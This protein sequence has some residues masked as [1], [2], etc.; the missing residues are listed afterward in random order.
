MSAEA[1]LEFEM[2]FGSGIE[3]GLA[4]LVA[5]Y[6]PEPGLYDEMLTAAGRIRPPWNDLLGQLAALGPER[7]ERAFEAAD[8]HLRNAGVVFRVYDDPGGADRPWPL[9]HMPMVLGGSDWATLAAGITQRARLHEALLADLNGD[10]RVIAEGHLPAALVA[11][12]G[13][14]LRPLHRVTP[15]GGHHLHLFAADVSRGPDGRWWVIGDRTQAPSGLGYAIENRIALSRAL[16]DPFRSLHVDRL[17]GFY[18][19]FRAALSAAT[20]RSDPRIALLTPGPA[21]ETYFEHAYLARSLGFL[22]A[23]GGDLVVHDRRVY[24]RTIDG[25]QRIDAI[26]RRIDADFADPLELNAASRLGVP[27]LVDAVRAGTIVVA[28]ALGSGLAE[29]P[30]LN[31]YLPGLARHLLDE[32]LILPSVATWWCGDAS[33]RRAV[34]QTLDDKVIFPAFGRSLRDQMDNAGV[35]G[36]KLTEAERTRIVQMIERRGFDFVGQEPVRLATTPVWEKGRLVPRPY[37]LRVFACRGPAGWMVMP[38]GLCR[39][40]ERGDARSLSMQRGGR[41]ADVWVIA[42]RR[43]DA[44]PAVLEREDVEISRETGALPARAADN[45][46]WLGRYLE[47]ADATLRLVRNLLGRNAD[48]GPSDGED[49]P[50]GQLAAILASWGAIPLA[51]EDPMLAAS[52]AL[53]SSLVGA[54][55][56]I[57]DNAHRTAMAVRD[58]LSPDAW[59]TLGDLKDAFR[60]E[61]APLA[62]AIEPGT[63]DSLV[64]TEAMSTRVAAALRTIAALSGLAHENMNRLGGWHFLDLGIRI[65]RAIAVARFA[66]RLSDKADADLT[67]LDSLLDLVD[68][69]TAYRARYFTGPT[70][71]RVLDQV[72]LDVSHPRSVAY[73]V[74]EVVSHLQRLALETPGNRSGAAETAAIRLRAELA[75]ASAAEFGEDRIL[76]LESHLMSISDAITR[77][78]LSGPLP[79]AEETDPA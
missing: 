46:F 79:P 22:L 44:G 31:G 6:R 26:V 64:R 41:S 30:A 75:K 17:A 74:D 77:R 50:A 38:G 4:S 54:L 7:T 66:R 27:G 67:S 73:Q 78:Y 43:P 9:A 33:A 37:A 25:P 19:Q 40:S 59:R 10:G 8:R 24:V 47:R 58:R 65:E 53:C 11:G 69:Q 32:E 2:R 60:A 63:S 14:F 35:L 12:N 29:A 42:E 68:A 15:A 45:L 16:P 34:L 1:Q 51:M 28:N 48:A 36:S 52:A 61:D 13:E 18:Q 56:A 21:N 62:A 57:V 55:P 72:L 5:G 3:A 70:R 23:E 49:A 76:A 20:G 39:I 71:R